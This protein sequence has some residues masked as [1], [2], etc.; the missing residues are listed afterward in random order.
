MLEPVDAIRTE[1]VEKTFSSQED[2]PIGDG[3]ISL[4]D[5]KI[6]LLVDS[7]DGDNDPDF[8]ES[9]LPLALGITDPRQPGIELPMT[10]QERE[11]YDT[12]F[13]KLVDSIDPDDD[14]DDERDELDNDDD[15]DEDEGGLSEMPDDDDD[16]GLLPEGAEDDAKLFD[17]LSAFLTINPSPTDDQFHSLAV[18][19]GMDPEDLESKVYALMGLMLENEEISEETRELINSRFA[20]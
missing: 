16:D 17:L 7:T 1:E 10:S 5:M 15:D 20:T 6:S 12:P 19:I 14:G 8:D 13:H 2:S 9:E 11:M 18:A 3:V 4:G